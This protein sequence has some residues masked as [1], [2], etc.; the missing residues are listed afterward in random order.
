[1]KR[2]HIHVAVEDH[3][4]SIGFYST[5]FDAQPSVVKDDYAKWLLEDPRVN[6]AISDRARVTVGYGDLVEVRGLAVGMNSDDPWPMH[7]TVRV[8]DLRAGRIFEFRDLRTSARIEHG[9]ADFA[10]LKLRVI[11]SAVEDFELGR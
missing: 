4:K 9:G 3:A 7:G 1:M 2:L 8:D 6:F 10:L 5:L 11:S